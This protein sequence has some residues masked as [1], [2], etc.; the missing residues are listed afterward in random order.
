LKNSS[1]KRHDAKRI[2]DLVAKAFLPNNDPERKKYLGV[3][4]HDRK[5]H[6]VDNLIWRT[7]KEHGIYSASIPIDTSPTRECNVCKETLPI[8]NFP[9]DH[10]NHDTGVEGH[11]RHHCHKCISASRSPPTSEQQ[12]KRREKRLKDNYNLTLKEYDDMFKSQEG[13]CK[14]CRV[15][16]SGKSHSNIDHCHTTKKVRGLLCPN[17]NKALGMVGDNVAILQALIEY[18]QEHSAVAAEVRMPDC[19]ARGKAP[20][21]E[22]KHENSGVVRTAAQKETNSKTKKEA[23]VRKYEGLF[24]DALKI[25]VANPTGE[26]EKKWRHSVSRKNRDGKLP[27]SCLD[28]LKN[29]KGWT[30]SQ[31]TSHSTDSRIQTI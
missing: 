23:A 26:N 16:I 3:K 30:F 14:T 20:K 8:I 12:I 11:R 28:M 17:C 9:F 6:H 25:W 22:K 2:K 31:G 10:P 21:K 15:D 18:L 19:R 13:K 1:T 5:N 29:T 24:A 7:A 4:N 27:Q